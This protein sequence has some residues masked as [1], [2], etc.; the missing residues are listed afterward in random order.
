MELFELIRV[1]FED[2]HAYD[3]VSNTDKKKH[4]FM[5]NRRMSIKFPLQAHVLQHT[6]IDEVAVVDFWQR[7]LTKQ[8]KKTPFWMYVKGT[9]RAKEDKEK[10]TFKDTVMKQFAST[11]GYDERSVRDA[12]SM[13]PDKMKEEFK[14]F[15]KMTK[16]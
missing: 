10:K 1:M 13:F 9:K 3:A 7:F 8:Y 5:I 16:K 4:F 14:Q 12:A 15:E 6:K 2:P 11:Y